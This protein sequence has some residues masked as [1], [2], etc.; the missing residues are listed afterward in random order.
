MRLSCLHRL[1]CCV[2]TTPKDCTGSCLLTSLKNELVC[3]CAA[4]EIIYDLALCPGRERISIGSLN[5]SRDGETVFFRA[6]VHTTRAQGLYD[7][8]FCVFNTY[9]FLY[10]TAKMVFL[11]FRQRL[12]TIQALISADPN[13]ISKQMLKWVSSLEAESIVLVEGTVQKTEAEVKSTSVKDCEIIIS[14]V[15]V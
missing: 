8:E 13:K 14:K 11:S 3:V 6:R 9:N 10:E 2:R 5:V 4:T 1:L 12:D 7:D 15:R